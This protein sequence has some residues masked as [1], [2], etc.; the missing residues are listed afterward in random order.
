VFHGAASV[1][2]TAGVG[3]LLTVILK[4]NGNINI[5][6]T[7]TTF[8]IQDKIQQLAAFDLVKNDEPYI[9]QGDY[10]EL[11]SVSDQDITLSI[12]AF[13]IGLLGR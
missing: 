11:W 1:E 5:V 8:S 10:I 4:L 7:P 13:S 3:A 12:N 9:K 6:E 2:M